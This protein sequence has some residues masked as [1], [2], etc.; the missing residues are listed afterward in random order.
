MEVKGKAVRGL[1]G[2][3]YPAPISEGAAIAPGTPGEGVLAPSARSMRRRSLRGDLGATPCLR[4]VSELAGDWG[5]RLTGA[6]LHRG[7]G[8]ARALRIFVAK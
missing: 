2:A 7:R 1:R 3:T 4:Y 6:A 5:K 8:T